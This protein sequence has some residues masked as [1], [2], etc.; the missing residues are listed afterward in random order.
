MDMSRLITFFSVVVIGFPHISFA[1]IVQCGHGISYDCGTCELIALGN[2]FIDFL[3]VIM[4][5]MAG[6]IFCYAG[7]LMV[8][9]AGNA[10]QFKRGRQIFT[11]VVIGLVIML[12]A[13]LIVDITMR[14]FLP[15]GRVNYGGGISGLWSDIQCTENAPVQDADPT[16]Q[17]TTFYPDVYDNGLP[18][19]ESV[20]PGAGA[21]VVLVDPVTGS[22]VTY[23]GY[24]FDSGIVGLVEDIATDNGLRVSSGYR[25]PERN[26]AVGGVPNSY[27]L[28]GRAADFVG[29]TA[30]M[31]AGAAQARAAGC[32]AIIHNAGSGTH[33]HIQCP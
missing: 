23:A 20:D 7:F 12:V 3:I 30:Q 27:H 2:N 22:L 25:T 13:W 32:T 26:A 17:G 15:G 21:G 28:T 14:T 1:Q 11:N 19:D 31:N 10:G 9:S 33:L 24:Q 5:V 29:T 8:T 6:I 16:Q 4:T 18:L